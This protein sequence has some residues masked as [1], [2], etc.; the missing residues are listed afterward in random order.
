MPSSNALRLGNL[1]I[2][3]GYLTREEV[4]AGHAMQ[5]AKALK[6]GKF[7]LANVERVMVRGKFARPAPAP[8]RR[9]PC[10]G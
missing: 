6:H 10:R 3:K 4:V 7:D 9:S 8:P 2:E 5:P 1:L